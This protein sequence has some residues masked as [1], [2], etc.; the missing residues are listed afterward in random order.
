[1]LQPEIEKV[2]VTTDTLSTKNQLNNS[3]PIKD[4]LQKNG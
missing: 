2:F 3:V 1:M 4:S